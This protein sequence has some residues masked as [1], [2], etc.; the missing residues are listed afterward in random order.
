MAK[1]YETMQKINTPGTPEAKRVEEV[2][3]EMPEAKAY[4]RQE[5]RL[6]RAEE[7]LDAAEAALPSGAAGAE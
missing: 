4:H 5:E 2:L 3:A 7:A 6:A 1:A